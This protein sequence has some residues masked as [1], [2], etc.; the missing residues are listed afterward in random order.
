MHVWNSH[1]LRGSLLLVRVT[2]ELSDGRSA[3]DLCRQVPGD[4]GA[5][6]GRGEGREEGDEGRVRQGLR[7]RLL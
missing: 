1:W 5:L 2:L 4:E 7:L 6:H 3:R